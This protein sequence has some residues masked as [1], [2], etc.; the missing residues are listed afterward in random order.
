MKM[1]CPICIEKYN[2]TKHK[3]ILCFHCQ[4][5]ACLN[6]VKKFIL[7]NICDKCMYC[8]IKWDRR[9]MVNNLTKV[10]CDKDYRFHRNKILKERCKCMLQSLTPISF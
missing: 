9:F 3:K 5:P 2:K 7:S 8:N 10:F 1:D 6:C 4:K